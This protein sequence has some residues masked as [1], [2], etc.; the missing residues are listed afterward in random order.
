MAL[1]GEEAGVSGSGPASLGTGY[2]GHGVQLEEVEGKG[3]P[4]R[5]VGETLK[6]NE[7]RDSCA[8]RAS[9]AGRHLYHSSHNPPPPWASQVALVVKNPPVN[10]EDLRDADS[11]L[12]LGRSLGKGMA[13]HSSVLAWRIPRTEE[14]GR[15]QSMGSTES[16]MTEAT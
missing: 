1:P 10:A 6:L 5:V 3:H 9:S 8:D 15:L 2:S 16:D 11:I 7:V 13:T 12:G 14:A 4:T